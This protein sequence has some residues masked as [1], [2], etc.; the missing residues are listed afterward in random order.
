MKNNL[1]VTKK[2]V[3]NLL[4]NVKY[5][6]FDWQVSCFGAYIKNEKIHYFIS[7][8]A[9]GLDENVYNNTYDEIVIFDDSDFLID[10]I[11]ENTLKSSVESYQS[12][13]KM[14]VQDYLNQ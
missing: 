11:K 4:R 6:P 10:D 3:R 13:F 12:D 8:K 7:Y 9:Q 1:R 5:S 2:D 14:L